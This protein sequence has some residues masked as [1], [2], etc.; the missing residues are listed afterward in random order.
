MSYQCLRSENLDRTV[1]RAGAA[2]RTTKLAL[3]AAALAGLSSPAFAVTTGPSE[4]SA[5][6]VTTPLAGPTVDTRSAPA[7][8]QTATAADIEASHALDL[9]AYMN[10]TLGSV[11]VNDIQNNP[12][13]P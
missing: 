4:V 5:V 13:Q 3:F 12:L 10:R 9:T 6:V 2:S 11:Y 8:G 7:P 1:D